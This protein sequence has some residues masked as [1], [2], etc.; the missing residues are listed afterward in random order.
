M[1]EDR[2][3]HTGQETSRKVWGVLVVLVSGMKVDGGG[4]DGG[5]VGKGGERSCCVKWGCHKEK[6]CVVSFA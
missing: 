6:Q 3:G 5:G 4:S 1:G 2:V